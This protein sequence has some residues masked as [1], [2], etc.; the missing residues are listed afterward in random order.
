MAKITLTGKVTRLELKDRAPY[1]P[2]IGRYS[3][4]TEYREFY[5]DIALETDKGTVYFKTPASMRRVT[6]GGP[7][8][9][10]CYSLG[11][12]AA[13]W[14]KEVGENAVAEAGRPNDN[15]LVS[16]VAEGDMIEVEGRMKTEKVSRKGNPYRVI[17]HAKLVSV[18][19]IVDGA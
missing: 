7:F 18:L 4:N 5:L 16:L 13:T 14:M 17:T 15:T 6:M 2:Y 3:P 1:D 11:A 10:V 9:V 12:S 8:A 19:E